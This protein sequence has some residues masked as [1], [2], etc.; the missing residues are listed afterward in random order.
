MVRLVESEF[1]NPGE[2]VNPPVPTPV[3][4]VGQGI[5]YDLR[6]PEFAISMAKAGADILTYPSSFTVPTGADHW[7][8]LLRARAI[9]NQ[10][11]VVSA[12]QVGVHNPKRSSW[13]HSMVVDPWGAVIAQCGDG[14]GLALAIIDPQHHQRARSRLPVWTDR[15]P[16]IY[17]EVL[18]AE[19]QVEIDSC[20]SYQFGQV[21][22][23]SSQVFLRTRFSF[24]FVNHRPF[25]PGHSL[26]APLRPSAKRIAD[27]NQAE[28]SDLFSTVQ[29]VQK[30]L[31][32]EHQAL[33]SLIAVQDGPEAGRSVEHL[34]VH[35]LPRKAG[36]FDS[37]T[38]Y[39][40]LAQHDKDD[41][42]IRSEED[43]KEECYRIRRYFY[44]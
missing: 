37:D 2:K 34:H 12:A 13:G 36:D 18:P 24:A 20:D 1:S 17:G 41:S 3:G 5:C 8:V 26:V 19:N 4:K 32:A 6:F 43:M 11:Y 31:E 23:T 14:V 9:E 44:E 35:I 27:L 16:D 28:I 10:C 39:A 33:S 29:R 21:I 30:A 22:I 15:R 7:E 38:I 42:K 25:L 40:S